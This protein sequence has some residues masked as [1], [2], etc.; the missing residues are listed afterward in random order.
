MGSWQR[1]EEDEELFW[2]NKDDELVD[3]LVPDNEK[4]KIHGGKGAPHRKKNEKIAT[5]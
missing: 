2:S 5:S 4:K 3:L 1:T